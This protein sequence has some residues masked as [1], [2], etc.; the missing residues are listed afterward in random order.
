VFALPT[1]GLVYRPE[2]AP[3]TFGLGVFAVAGFRIDY[4]G[5]RG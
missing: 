4:P 3:V 1:L 5:K 2:D